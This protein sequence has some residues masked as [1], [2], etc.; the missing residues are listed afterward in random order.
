ML[1]NKSVQIFHQY[2]LK[3]DTFHAYKIRDFKIN[4]KNYGY[5]YRDLCTTTTNNN[6][7]QYKEKQMWYQTV[8]L[9]KIVMR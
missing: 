2:N 4:V 1:K 6:N 5:M 8:V 7:V 9:A 3:T